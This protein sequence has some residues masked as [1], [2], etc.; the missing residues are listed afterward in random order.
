[1][2]EGEKGMHTASNSSPPAPRLLL[3][4]RVDHLCATEAMS[5]SSVQILL[6]RNDKG[7]RGGRRKRELKGADGWCWMAPVGREMGGAVGDMLQR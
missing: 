1:M 7:R 5:T 4:R 3:L 6:C 2:Q